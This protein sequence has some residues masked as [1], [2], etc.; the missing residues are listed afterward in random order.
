MSF[1][2]FIAGNASPS[3]MKQHGF[4]QWHYYSGDAHDP[5]VQEVIR[6]QFQG[7]LTSPIVPRVFCRP[8]PTCN[9]DTFTVS[10]GATGDFTL[11]YY[12]LK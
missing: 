8:Y 4:Q 11:V 5:S 3:W 1:V 2:T 6:S 9:K 10:P 7:L 12:D